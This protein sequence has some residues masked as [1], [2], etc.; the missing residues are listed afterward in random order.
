MRN[1]L[2]VR[3][4]FVLLAVLSYLDMPSDRC[5]LAVVHHL[6]MWKLRFDWHL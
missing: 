2:W 1:S 3:N 6:S 5:G 4:R